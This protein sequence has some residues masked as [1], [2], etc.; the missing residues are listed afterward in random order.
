MIR[1]GEA[2]HSLLYYEKA[3]AVYDELVKYNQNEGYRQLYILSLH[4]NEWEKMKT[5]GQ[6]ICTMDSGSM[7]LHFLFT[8]SYYTR[9]FEHAK[10]NYENIRKN[11]S[12]EDTLD[13]IRSVKYGYVLYNLDQKEE[14]MKIFNQQ[15][16]YHKES[17]RKNSFLATGRWGGASH[18]TLAAIYA[19]LGD[20]DK[21][22][23][24]LFDIEK[25]AFSGWNTARMQVDPM[26]ENLWDD[27]EFKAIIQR[28]QTKFAVI[29]N[30]ID[31]LEEMGEL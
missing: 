11:V 12:K 13:L 3:E 7:C 15:I 24:F 9:S 4:K 25:G 5:Y 27:E 1:L 21:A 20:K 26:F 6:K 30:N 17:I 8:W 28:E 14:A 2:Y 22:Y 16:E 31:R 18:Y 19:F 10:K 29:R 23:S